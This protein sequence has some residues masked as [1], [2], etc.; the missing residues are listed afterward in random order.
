MNR[1]DNFIEEFCNH[2]EI[3]LK[4]IFD[5]FY[6]QDMTND[7]SI[8]ALLSRWTK[9][10]ILFRVK[11]GV[12]V[13]TNERKKLFKLSANKTEKRLAKIFETQYPELKYA[14]WNT[15]CLNRLMIHQHFSSFYIFETESEILDSVFYLLKDNKMNVFMGDNLDDLQMFLYKADNPIILRK[16]VSRSPLVKKDKVSFPAIEKILV[17]IFIDH[18]L[19]NFVQGSELNHIYNAVFEDYVVNV[20]KL[21]NYADRRKAKGEIQNYIRQTIHNPDVIALL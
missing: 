18:T 12:Y 6:S 21:L 2:K 8:T 1:I 15:D 10:G 4:E 20:S 9:Q 14:V 13:L 16:L 5:Y 3:S 17:D 19:F 11:R 7:K